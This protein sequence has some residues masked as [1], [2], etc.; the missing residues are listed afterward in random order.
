MRTWIR[1]GVSGQEHIDNTRGG[2][3]LVNHQSFLDPLFAAVFL[4]RPV[5]YLARDSLFRV[6]VLGAILRSTNVIP[7]SREAVRSGSIRTAIE[8]LEQ[9]FLVGIFPEGTRSSGDAPGRFR[10]GFL[11]LIRRSNTPVYPVG[12]A[13]ADRILPKGSWFIRPRRVE[14]VYGAPLSEQQLEVLRSEKDERELA[15]FARS[16][17]AECQRQAAGRLK[18]R[19]SGS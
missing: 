3:F 8:N 12:I 7:I 6:P 16:L 19:R 1:A 15:D 4:T 11:A 18:S 17:V 14:I 10:P 13:G 9:G 2:L 5:S